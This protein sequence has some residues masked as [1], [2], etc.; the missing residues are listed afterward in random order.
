M[1]I[2]RRVSRIQIPEDIDPHL[3]VRKKLVAAELVSRTRALF[4]LGRTLCDRV[5]RDLRFEMRLTL[6]GDWSILDRVESAGYDLF[7][8][9]PRYGLTGKLALAWRA[10]RW[11]PRPS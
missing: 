1:R 7:R 6:L 10:W 11:A 4:Q 2:L 8:R 5:G 9:R 3:G